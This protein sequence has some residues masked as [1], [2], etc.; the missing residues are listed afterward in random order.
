MPKRPVF[1]TGCTD[2]HHDILGRNARAD[3]EQFDESRVERLLTGPAAGATT[4]DVN[5]DEIAA[6][7]P[8]A[9]FPVIYQFTRLAL[10][11]DLK[12]IPR[13]NLERLL[14]RILQAR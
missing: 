10:L 2:D 12:T 13:R 11:K 5:Q 7:R 4:G 14:K 3:S 9:V 1:H 8:T 6:T